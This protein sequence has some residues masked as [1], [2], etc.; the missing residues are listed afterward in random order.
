MQVNAICFIDNSEELMTPLITPDNQGPWVVRYLWIKHR[1]DNEKFVKN[2]F[3]AG[4]T[5]GLNV[6]KQT[7]HLQEQWKNHNQAF[8]QSAEN[9]D[10]IWRVKAYNSVSNSIDYIEVWKDLNTVYKIFD[11]E[12]E[13]ESGSVWNEDQ[14]K[15]LGQGVW[16]AGFVV[17][18]YRPYKSISK[19]CALTF[20]K[21]FVERY[22]NKDG[23]IINTP[24]K[25]EN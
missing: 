2:Y 25:K 10:L 12:L 18:H 15:G 8:N 7:V 14:K 13:L 21:Q 5:T 19:E 23:C 24:Y 9:G 4:N 20:Y 17:R 6:R 16:D 1:D 3:N 22:K 11:K